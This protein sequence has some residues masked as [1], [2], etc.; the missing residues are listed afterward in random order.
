M[1]LH[2][3]RVVLA[4]DGVIFTASDEDP[5]EVHL[6]RMAGREP[7]ER[8]TELPGVHDGVAGGSVLVVISAGMDAAAQTTTVRRDGETMA[9]IRSFAEA[10]NLEPRISLGRFGPRA[11]R[12]AS[13][14]VAIRVRPHLCRCCS[15]H[16]EARTSSGC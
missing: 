10:P 5:T 16:T 6:W 7:P 8:L 9:A 3:W 13:P 15:I 1:G 11:R 2:V 12:R 14:H 4:G